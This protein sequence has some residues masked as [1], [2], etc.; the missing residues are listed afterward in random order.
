MERSITEAGRAAA[1]ME[2]I[3]TSIAVNVVTTTGIATSQREFWRR[4]MR[5]YVSVVVGGA[6]Y[7]DRNK[8]LKFAG[9][10]RV[11]NDGM[12]PAHNV[13]TAIKAAIVKVPIDP[14]FD[15]TLPDIKEQFGP[16]IGPRQFREYSGIVES[17]VP[18]QDVD[19]IKDL[20]SKTALF[21]WG[22]V[23]YKDAFGEPH[24]ANFAQILYWLADNTVWGVYDPGHNDSD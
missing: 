16:A 1:A 18:D 22:K 19:N 8:K 9:R 21:V 20:S 6:T 10:P 12:T 7:Q 23:T 17:Y 14:N 11:I 4:Q 2:G 24:F 3:A 13:K 15:F 5:A